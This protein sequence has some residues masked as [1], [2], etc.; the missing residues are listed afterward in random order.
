MSSDCDGL[1]EL[2]RE[3][4]SK[5]DCMVKVWMSLMSRF[6]RPFHVPSLSL[7]PFLS[8]AVS[9]SLWLSVSELSL[10][11]CVSLGLSFRPYLSLLLCLCHSSYL[12][13]LSCS[14]SCPSLPSLIVSRFPRP[15]FPFTSRASCPHCR[16][17][18]ICL[19]GHARG[20]VMLL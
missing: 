6:L 18:S 2:F 14:P 16:C 5:S 20:V 17:F 8:H 3:C 12:C 1:R 7:T 13:Q 9:A 11:D 10:C 15:Y 4:L 19:L